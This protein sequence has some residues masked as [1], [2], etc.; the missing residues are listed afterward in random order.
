[1]LDVLEDQ[2]VRA[3]LA[4]RIEELDA[5]LPLDDERLDDLFSET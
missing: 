3:D 1:V 5:R 2:R 4:D